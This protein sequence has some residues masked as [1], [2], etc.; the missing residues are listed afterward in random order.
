MM[1]AAVLL[2]LLT[3]CMVRQL[4]AQDHPA[5][6]NDIQVIKK[7]DNIYAPPEHPIL[8]IGSSSIRKWDDLERTFAKYKVMNR[9]IGGAVV[10]DITRYANDIVFPYHPRQV[11]IYVGENDLVDEQSTADSILVRTRRLLQLIREGLPGIPIVYIS[12][13]PSPVREKYLDKAI[14]ANNLIREY[15]STQKNMAFVDVFH[16][17]L[18]ADGKPMPELFIEDRL[19]LNPDGYRIWQ[20]AIKPC[21]IKE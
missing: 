18:T 13:K 2:V 7:Y 6:W 10:N 12:I 9:G 14:A 11:V 5:Y 15:I 4:A 19:H 8:F 21:L 3:T 20:K 1:K 17:M 16:K